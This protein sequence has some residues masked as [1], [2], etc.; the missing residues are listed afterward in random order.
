MDCLL[1]AAIDMPGKKSWGVAE[2]LF[3]FEMVWYTGGIN[4]AEE[5]ASNFDDRLLT[6][7]QDGWIERIGSI[8]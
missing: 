4:A 3:F 1:P 6:R 2:L 7:H 8:R 5:G